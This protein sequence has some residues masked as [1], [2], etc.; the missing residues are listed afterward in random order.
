MSEIVSWHL[1]DR[2]KITIYDPTSG[3]GSLLINIG[4]A[5][6]RRNGDPDAIKYYAQEL[7]EN[8]Y[9]LT[10]MN[11]VMRGI[12]PDNIVTRNGDTL[13]DDWPWFDTLDNKEETYEPLFVD[14]VVSNPPYSQNWDPEEKDIDARFAYGLAPKSKADYA[15]L[16]HDL[17]HLRPDGI[18]CIVLPHGVLFRGGEEGTIRKNLVENRH[19]Q[20]IIGLPANIFFGTGI[21]TIIMVLRKQRDESGVLVVDASRHFVKE[22]KNNKLRASDIKR[23]ADAVT[24]NWTA[25]K[26]SRLVSIE[27][28]RAN[29]YN[30]NIPRY[31]DS[32]EAAESWDIYA[33]MFGGVPASEVDALG[34]Y[35]DVWPS[36]KEELYELGEPCYQPKTPDVGKAVAA[37]QDVVSF[38]EDFEGAMRDFP[39]ELKVRLIDNLET[40]D[41]VAG[42]AVLSEIL[43][44]M[45]ESIP[46]VS[47]YEAYQILDDAWSTIT[48]DVETIQAEGFD[49]IR[50]VDPNMVLK[51]Q[52]GQEV[53]VQDGW[54]GRILPF[55]LVQRELLEDELGQI[56][57]LEMRLEEISQAVGEMLEGLDEEERESAAVN[58][59]GDAFVAAELKKAVKA[60]GKNPESEF[61][62]VLVK[63]QQLLDEEK[64]LKK[65]VK[66]LVS[67]LEDKTKKTIERLDNSQCIQ[68]LEAKWIVPLHEGLQALPKGVL[69]DFASKVVALNSKYAVTHSDVCSQ[70]SEAERELSAMLG[71]LTGDAADLAGIN[72]LM[73]LLG[74]E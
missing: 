29:D 33:S 15:F 21:P 49:A 2:E 68:L 3:S 27:E 58:D 12:L 71:E 66:D 7:K 38:V 53:E 25:D 10:R 16:L 40:V 32:S 5:V 69:D 1:A 14:A 19:I 54:V 43:D 64:Q 6:A 56:R 55:E 59:E 46:L 42:E 35:W 57:E 30:L 31:V 34:E 37:N 24:N 62:N 41:A 17:F 72:E 45:L 39:W 73:T 36:L 4:K 13:E 67:E 74:G 44:G 61:D 28:I 65:Q 26:F 23:I 11:L 18:M 51:K 47:G 20:A 8:T 50:A 52:K 60:I 70:I 22:G 63:A 9:N 48:I